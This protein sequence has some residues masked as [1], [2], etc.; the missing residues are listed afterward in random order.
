LLA[1]VRS[2]AVETMK[3]A[4]HAVVEASPDVI[5]TGVLLPD[6]DGAELIENVRRLA[7]APSFVVVTGANSD[8][9]RERY[10]AVGV[11]RFVEDPHDP[12]ALQI[13]ITTLR[14]RPQGSVPPAET[15]RLLGRMTSGIVHDLNNYLH[16]LDVTLQLLRRHPNDEQLWKQSHTAVQTMSRLNTT[17]LGYALLV[18]APVDATATRLVGVVCHLR[19][20]PDGRGPEDRKRRR[21][22]GRSVRAPRIQ[23]SKRR[24]SPLQRSGRCPRRDG[25]RRLAHRAHGRPLD[26]RGTRCAHDERRRANERAA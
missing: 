24:H 7:K 20:A 4:L 26:G 14:R 18:A 25:E 19:S 11:D 13:A 6:G 2:G 5:V 10:L 3:S 9:Q 16:V 22:A 17:L 15:Q 12:R 23:R 8:L 1:S 21:H